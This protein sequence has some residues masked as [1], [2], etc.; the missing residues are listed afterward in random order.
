MSI[1]RRLTIPEGREASCGRKNARWALMAA[2]L[3]LVAAAHIALVLWAAVH[4]VP[5][6]AICGAPGAVLTGAGAL[7]C[8]QQAIYW[9]KRMNTKR[10]YASAE[11]SISRI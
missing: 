2:S 8:R 6:L 1:H 5:I 4:A 10:A 3:W 7:W 11:N 9:R